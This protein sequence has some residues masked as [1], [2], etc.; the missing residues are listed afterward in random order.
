MALFEW[1]MTGIG[2]SYADQWRLREV[3]RGCQADGGSGGGKVGGH[4]ND[5]GQSN[6]VCCTCTVHRSTGKLYTLC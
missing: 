1:E 6:H 4:G 3:V 2:S 5:N